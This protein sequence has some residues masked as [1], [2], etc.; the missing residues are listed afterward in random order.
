MTLRD[1][2]PQGSASCGYCRVLSSLWSYRPCVI[3]DPRAVIALREEPFVDNYSKCRVPGSLGSY[4]PCVIVDPRAVI[5]LR[6]EPFV[7]SLQ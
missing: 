7:D 6:E 3:V 5:A 1:V 4:R 2:L